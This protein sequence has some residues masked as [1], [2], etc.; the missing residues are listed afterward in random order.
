MTIFARRRLQAMLNDLAPHLS[1]E[2]S[3]ALL[4]CLNDKKRVEQALPAEMEL[5]LLW[6]ISKLGDI[7]IEPEW[8]GDSKRPDAVTE[9]L[10]SGRI[11]A[12]EIASPNDNSISGEAEMDAIA[13]QIGAVAHEARKGSGQYLRYTFRE[14]SGY[15]GRQYFRRRMAPRDFELG[16]ELSAQVRDWIKSGRSTQE[17][18]RLVAPGLD[19][20]VEHT[21]HKQVRFH[22]IFSSM[23]PEA[24][25][26]ED[27]PLFELLRRKRRQLKAAAPG[28]LRLIFLA[29]LAPQDRPGW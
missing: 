23:P 2:K 14:E 5:A 29:D 8:W 10:V 19:A 15:R 9:R 1:G 12:I 26:L 3:K 4:R 16:D 6:A 13:L 24:H 28:T 22:N 11:A 25:S 20:V 17:R 27:N 21:V 18:L 7:E